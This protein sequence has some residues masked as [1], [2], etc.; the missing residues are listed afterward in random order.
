MVL[1][2]LTPVTNT[3]VLILIVAMNT[4]I[5]GRGIVD[6]QNVASIANDKNNFKIKFK[7]TL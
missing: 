2:I 4:Y 1:L 7:K 6:I 5:E 3:L